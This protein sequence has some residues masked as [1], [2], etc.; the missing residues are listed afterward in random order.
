MLTEALLLKIKDPELVKLVERQSVSL[1]NMRSLLN[2]LLDISKLDADAVMVEIE[3]VD[4]LKVI[5]EVCLGFQAEAEEKGL[6]LLVEAQSRVVRSDRNLLQQI[7][8]NL[9]GNAI[10]YTKKGNIKVISSIVGDNIRVEV[11]DTGVGIAEDQLP[12][13]FDEFYQ[14]GRDPQEGNAGLGLGLAI[15]YRIAEKLDSRI[16]VQS[17]VGRGSTFSFELPLSQNLLP[18]KQR[19][20]T[21]RYIPLQEE[22]AVFLVDDDPAVLKSTRFRLSLQKGL[23]IFTASSP[24]EADELLDHLAPRKPDIIVTDYHLGTKKN[25]VDIIQDI[26][27]RTGSSIPAILM[28]GDTAIDVVKLKR[29]DINVVFKPTNGSELVDTIL[30]LL[31]S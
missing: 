31:S 5:E 2:S 23:E 6:R 25:G 12:H 24:K 20:K 22:K 3:D 27:K 30:R 16:E 29:D 7:L 28:S 15:A 17:K 9:I 18:K 21:E 13:I 8:Q 14:I 19:P 26:R 10:R 4:L 1:G 11:Q